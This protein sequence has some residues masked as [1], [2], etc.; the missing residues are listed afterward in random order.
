VERDDY[1]FITLLVLAVARRNF[2]YI[3]GGGRGLYRWIWMVLVHPGSKVGVQFKSSMRYWPVRLYLL[4]P[5]DRIE[6]GRSISPL[7]ARVDGR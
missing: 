6:D 3:F 7:F 5:V 4:R 2:E 1:P